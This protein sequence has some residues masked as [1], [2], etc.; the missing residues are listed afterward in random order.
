MTVTAVGVELLSTSALGPGQ[1]N[2]GPA[3][4]DRVHPKWNPS[5]H[6]TRPVGQAESPRYVTPQLRQ[7]KRLMIWGAISLGRKYP[8][9]KIDLENEKLNGQR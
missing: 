7:G 9:V 1:P 2:V 8:L 4:H 3:K 5:R 6:V